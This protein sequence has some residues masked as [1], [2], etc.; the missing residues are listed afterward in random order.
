M[1]RSG[2]TGIDHLLIPVRDLE[3][4]RM[5]WTRLGFTTSP[6]GTHLGRGT[7]NYCIMFEHDYLELFG[8]L[9]PTLASASYVNFLAEREGPMK[10]AWATRD[11]HVAAEALAGLGLHPSEVK[12]LQRQIELPEETAVPRFAIVSLPAEETPGLD[13]FLCA[14]LTPKL[15]RRPPWLQHPNGAVGIA[16]ITVAVADTE[17]LIPRYEYLFGP[18]NLH[19]TDDV[20]TVRAGRH[21]IIFATHDDV[22]VL[23][24]EIDP[25]PGDPCPAIA[26]VTLA[27]ADLDRTGDHL[28][29]WQIEHEVV[30]RRSIVVPASAA[31]GTNI[32][33][34]PAS[35]A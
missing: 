28:T 33:F 24:P 14:H 30:G 19:T 2:I 20:L 6:R 7:G 23:H 13:S 29:Q 32:E 1:T 4:A 17:S 25:L 12:D 31:M 3:T 26:V 11:A 10:L 5:V 35:R 18:G 16:G 9:D 21:R 22:A 15:M 34:I 27:V 8:V